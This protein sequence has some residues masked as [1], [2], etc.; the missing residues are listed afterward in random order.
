MKNQTITITVTGEC[1]SGKTTVIKEIRNA[2]SKA[3]IKKIEVN[4]LDPD[5]FENNDMLQGKRLDRLAERVRRGELHVCMREVQVNRSDHEDDI[6][7]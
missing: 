5:P 1:A 7:F 2:L 6:P 3:G 4:A